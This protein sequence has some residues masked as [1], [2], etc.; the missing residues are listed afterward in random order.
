MTIT[1]LFTS[2]LFSDRND[3]ALTNLYSLRQEKVRTWCSPTATRFAALICWRAS[4]HRWFLR[5][6]TPWRWMST[7]PPTRCFGVIFITAKY[8]G[9]PKPTVLW[10]SKSAQCF[11]NSVL[12][13][14]PSSVSLPSS[15]LPGSPCHTFWQRDGS[16]RACVSVTPAG[17]C[18][19]SG[20]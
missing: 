2:H 19:L 10:H 18:R 15:I 5:W 1:S 9:N 3:H 4:T 6:R 7:C 16:V 8:T 13:G 20:Y 11:L 12:V 17:L 14:R